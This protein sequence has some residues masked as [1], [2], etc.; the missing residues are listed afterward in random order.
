VVLQVRLHRQ[1]VHAGPVERRVCESL[2]LMHRVL[3]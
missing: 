3:T 2:R 1:Q